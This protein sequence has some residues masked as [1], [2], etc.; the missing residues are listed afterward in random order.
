MVARLK[1]VKKSTWTRFSMGLLLLAGIVLAIGSSPLRDYVTFHNIVESVER[2]RSSSWSSVAFYCFFTLAVLGL[3][4]TLFPIIGGVLFNFWTALA[5]NTL[6]CTL[7]S[8]IAFSLARFFGRSA[9]ETMLKGRLKMVDRFAAVKG[10][11]TVMILR[12]LGVPPFIVANYALGLSGIKR[13]DYLLGT[14]VGISPWMA[15]IT[16]A[17][18]ALWEAVLVGGERGFSMALLK[19]M[20]P[21][22]LLSFGIILTTAILY[23]LRKK[24]LPPVQSNL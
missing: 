21:M 4:I 19:I 5:L 8:W 12:L 6:A 1:R 7:G 16:F 2:A 24:K 22:M 17:S 9:V 23:I 10:F 13:R 18:H 15:L 11:R 14:L 20:W 3:P